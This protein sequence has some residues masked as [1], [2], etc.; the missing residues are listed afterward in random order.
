MREIIGY[1]PVQ[2][3]GSVRV[4]VPANVPLAISVLDREGRRVTAR[5]QNWLQLRAG[6]T[7]NCNGCHDHASGAVHGHP[8][9][10]ISAYSGA[11]QTGPPFP[12]TEPALFANFGETM[13]ETLTRLDSLE[14]NPDMNL[15]YEDVWTD[16]S[17]GLV[18]TPS[19]TYSYADLQTPAPVSQNCQD[20]WSNTCR[21]IIHYE[22]HI[23]PLWNLDR[24]ASTCTA[25][26]TTDNNTR[27][28]DAQLDLT[29]GISVEQAAH[30]KAY[31][32]LLFNDFEQELGANGLQD[33]MVDGPV[34]PVTGLPTQVPV[35]V[36][37]P[38]R[39]AGALA[40]TAFVTRF[41]AGGSHAGR[42][43]PA[44]LRLVFEWLDIGAQYYNDPFV[45]P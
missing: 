6:E 42:L 22:Q 32:E 15:I 40:S 38:M 34:D 9:G 8:E 11:L 28:P 25:C 3:D 43:D 29:D 19:F 18:K 24:G 2:P 4:K 14:L 31:R 5:H 45:V 26:H 21:T 17:G 37:P 16:D 1:V 41:N 20:N 27:V 10:P 7:V 36:S 33:V 44:E 30:F 23:H 12:N 13:A 35:V 39:T